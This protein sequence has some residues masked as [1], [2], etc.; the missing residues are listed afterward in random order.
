MKDTLTEALVKSLS[1]QWTA[2]VKH[3]IANKEPAHGTVCT[4]LFELAIQSSN[5]SSNSPRTESRPPVNEKV[6]LR[7]L[8]CI[9]DSSL[10]DFYRPSSSEIASKA[11]VQA[12]KSILSAAT[13]SKIWLEKTTIERI[14]KQASGPMS[15]EGGKQTGQATDVS[16]PDDNW[17]IDMELVEDSIRNNPKAFASML[18]KPSGSVPVANGSLDY[19]LNQL[20]ILYVNTNKRP[21]HPQVQNIVLPL[22]KAFI[23]TRQLVEFLQLLES[24]LRK[25]RNRD[26]CIWQSEELVLAISDV[27]EPNLSHDQIFEAIDRLWHDLDD[28]QLPNGASSVTANLVM[29]EIYLTGCRSEAALSHIAK[30]RANDLCKTLTATLSKTG[31]T[32]PSARWRVWMLIKILHSRWRFYGLAPLAETQSMAIEQINNI[33]RQSSGDEQL[34]LST[35]IELL[36]IFE[37]VLSCCEADYAK[38]GQSGFSIRWIQECLC[39]NRSDLTPDLTQV[40]MAHSR[41]LG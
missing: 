40:L 30:T 8:Y 31:S 3:C 33:L 12:A 4:T 34:D 38:S 22:V 32:K 17:V 19:L 18:D 7:E 13:A 5:A 1:Q 24:Q 29:L 39:R 25:N 28:D 36:H 9:C 20:S 11:Y 35:K 2:D 16:E 37:F 41:V 27:L 26:D 21:F 15:G 6:W 10:N 23:S 14:L